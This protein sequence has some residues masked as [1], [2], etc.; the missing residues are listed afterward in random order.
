MENDKAK[1]TNLTDQAYKMIKDK[2]VNGEF[3]QG[4]II[5]I[6]AIAEQL[7]IS[8]TPVTNACLRL[9]ESKFL[10]IVPKQGVIINV[11]TF[12]DAREIYELRAAIETYSAKRAFSNI[13]KLDIDYLKEN[14]TN[15]EMCVANKDIVGFMREDTSF[16]RFILTKSG[17]SHFFS[18]IN[19]LFDRAFLLG[20][21]TSENPIRVKQCLE[22]HFEIVKCLQNNN[23][24]GF[25]DA[26]E[27][28][29]INGYKSLTGN[30]QY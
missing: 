28:N 20:L 8:R 4:D 18:M 14:C 25:I 5:S 3:K 13:S 17:N 24:A 10:T 19:T 2:I 9:E 27:R 30:Y 11:I 26:I 23:Q 15:Q 7:S 21:K 1:I 12:N 29:I 6:S 22:E 16:H